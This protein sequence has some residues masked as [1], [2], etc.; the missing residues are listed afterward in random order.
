MLSR[1]KNYYISTDLIFFD[2]KRAA[3][4]LVKVALIGQKIREISELF[5]VV[6]PLSRLKYLDNEKNQPNILAN[7]LVFH[8]LEVIYYY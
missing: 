7:N 4:K 6:K 3:N 2:K 8:Y 5:C 1:Q